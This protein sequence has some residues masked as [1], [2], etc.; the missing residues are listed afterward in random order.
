[1]LNPLDVATSRRCV[2]AAVQRYAQLIAK[3]YIRVE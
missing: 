2:A 3:A 1:M